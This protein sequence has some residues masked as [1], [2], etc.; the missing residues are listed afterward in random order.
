M[1]CPEEDFNHRLLLEKCNKW[2][3][4]RKEKRLMRA[5]THLTRECNKPL[6]YHT[7]EFLRGW[8]NTRDVM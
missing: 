3:S 8:I 1:K 5:D 4:M 2:W 7:T 6:I